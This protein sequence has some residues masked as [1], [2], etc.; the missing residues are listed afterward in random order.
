VCLC[1]CVCVCVSVCVCTFCIDRGF[2]EPI[3][4]VLVYFV[5]TVVLLGLLEP[6]IEAYVH[7]V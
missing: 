3:L 7:F 6:I 2:T 4:A 1:V 5:L